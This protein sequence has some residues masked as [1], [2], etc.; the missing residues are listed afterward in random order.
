MTDD[1]CWYMSIC[2]R[3]LSR[4]QWASLF[5]LF[6]SILALSIQSDIPAD[7]HKH[8]AVNHLVPMATVLPSSAD[9]FSCH[10]APAQFS[11]VENQTH[12]DNLKSL[13]VDS[14][15]YFNFSHGHMLIL[16]QCL[17]S[18]MANIYNEKIF[19][20]GDG[21]TESIYVQNSKLYFFGTLFN[22]LTLFVHSEYRTKI[23][24]CGF[25]FGHNSFSILLIFTTAFYGLNV[26][27]ILKFRDNMFHLMSSQ[28]ITVTVITVSIYFFRF[29]PTLDFFL[30]APIVLLSIY[31]F[32]I[33]KHS[34]VLENGVDM[35]VRQVGVE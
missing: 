24:H 4:V 6:F 31:I 10:P 15:F 35:T 17:I 3:V 7:H 12:I 29:R 25:F 32:S 5:V 30:I 23:M 19:K 14:R 21:L 2:R 27:L 9:D 22:I 1:K 8:Q 34:K 16:I 11:Q 26:A 13:P 28:I 20:E 18:S 33:S